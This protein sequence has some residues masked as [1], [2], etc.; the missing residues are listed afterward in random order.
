M[1]LENKV[2]LVTGIGK[3]MGRATAIL[4][5]QE[6]AKVA[7]NARQ[8]DHLEETQAL[9]ES[10]GGQSFVV[11]GDVS[12]KKEADDLVQK[13][14]KEYG[15][16]EVKVKILQWLIVDGLMYSVNYLIMMEIILVIH[17]SLNQDM[18]IC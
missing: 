16:I 2:A 1:R 13:V 4:F 10:R 17:V 12:S 18:H 6:G 5:A 15:H 8:K 14:V 11:Q 7:I 9:I 3:G